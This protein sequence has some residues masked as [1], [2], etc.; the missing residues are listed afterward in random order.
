MGKTTQRLSG[1][2]VEH[3]MARDVVAVQ[4]DSSMAEA[5]KILRDYAISGVPVVDD[6]G[7][8]IG[9]LSA[10]DFVDSKSEESPAHPPVVHVTTTPDS[11]GLARAEVLDE[12]TVRANMSPKVETILEHLTLVD[13]GRLM[14]E[15][16]IHRL[17]VVDRHGRPI[18]IV[19]SLDLV[20]AL[21]HAAEELAD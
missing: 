14:C 5:A 20:S 18:G 15:E 10:S 4:A 7:R 21:V 6:T 13:A 3:V 1:M 11:T 17:I 19:S 2:R 16:H 12:T 9:V 8:C